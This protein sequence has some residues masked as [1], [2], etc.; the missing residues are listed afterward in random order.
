M[1]LV[2]V[3]LA[4]VGVEVVV[5]NVVFA[6]V[7]VFGVIC[8][9]VVFGVLALSIRRAAAEYSCRARYNGIS[10][11]ISLCSFA[12]LRVHCIALHVITRS[13]C[14]DVLYVLH[15]RGGT[16][17]KMFDPRAP[18]P[19]QLMSLLQSYIYVY[20]CICGQI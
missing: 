8:V 13:S 20:I 5:V 7:L 16:K 1:V 3:D 2:V 10:N 9:L 17:Q 14:G 6:F 15:S 4:A 19:K 11:D 12:C 18:G